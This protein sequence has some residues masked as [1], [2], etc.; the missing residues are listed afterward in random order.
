MNPL[1][2]GGDGVLALSCSPL[3]KK[4]DIDMLLLKE[5]FLEAGIMSLLR[6]VILC[7]TSSSLSIVVHSFVC[8]VQRS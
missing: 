2:P 8:G 3:R 1:Y 6:D 5:S 7:A 4:E